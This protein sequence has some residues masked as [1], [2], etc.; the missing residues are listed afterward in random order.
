MPTSRLKTKMA[1][2]PHVKRGGG[3]KKTIANDMKMV[4]HHKT[5]EHSTHM[6]EKGRPRHRV[7]HRTTTVFESGMDK[8]KPSWQAGY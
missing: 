5:V 3:S 2:K 1:P 8:S 7:E 6:D 4:H